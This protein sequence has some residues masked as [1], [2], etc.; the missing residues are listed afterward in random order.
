MRAGTHLMPSDRP[1]PAILP[2]LLF[3]L[4]LHALL[5]TAVPMLRGLPFSQDDLP[6]AIELVALP[7]RAP[8]PPAGRVVDVP[9]PPVKQENPDAKLL[10]KQGNRVEQETLNL[11]TPGAP[12]PPAAQIRPRATAEQARFQAEVEQ[13]KSEID[14]LRKKRAAQRLQAR[15]NAQEF[16]RLRAQ[17][18]A[19]ARRGNGGVN[20]PLD[21]VRRGPGTRLNTREF[22]ESQYFLDF[23]TSFGVVF[24]ASDVTL[25]LHFPGEFRSRPRT[26][27][28]IEVN[29]D[30]SLG[31]ARVFSSSGYAALDR[32]A[33][34]AARRVFPFDPPPPKLLTTRDTLRF[35]FEIIY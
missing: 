7:S 9:P 19:E 27:L 26:V 32:D 34:D 4:L 13:I 29:A 22:E 18:A 17:A 5:V 2:F 3:S 28:S 6:R 21:D 14:A 24:R 20:E 23:K 10:A 8:A 15:L 33:L 31:D 25:G 16:E 12:S 30:G 11:G 35:G 1:S